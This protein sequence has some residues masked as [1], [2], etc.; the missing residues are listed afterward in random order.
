LRE[1]NLVCLLDGGLDDL[2]LLRRKS[3]GKLSIELRLGF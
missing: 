2:L 1:G 3:G